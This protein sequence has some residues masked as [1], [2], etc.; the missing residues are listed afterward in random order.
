MP[1]A[2]PLIGIFVPRPATRVQRSRQSR[3]Y[4][5]DPKGIFSV[6][7]SNR[8]TLEQRAAAIRSAFGSLVQSIRIY[9]YIIYARGVMTRRGSIHVK[10]YNIQY[11][12]NIVCLR[13]RGRFARR[14]TKFICAQLDFCNYQNVGRLTIIIVWPVGMVGGGGRLGNS[15]PETFFFF[16]PIHC[17]RFYPVIS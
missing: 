2:R 8:L 3:V 9:M 17:R 12:R 5:L 6:Q 14:R 1:V 11:T 10:V 16:S 4:S 7:I 13:S 15:F